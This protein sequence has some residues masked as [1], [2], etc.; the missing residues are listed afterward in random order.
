MASE[1]W[2][3]FKTPAPPPSPC[4]RSRWDSSSTRFSNDARHS[5]HVN[6]R[7]EEE[8]EGMTGGRGAEGRLPEFGGLPPPF[9]AIE[10]RRASLR[11]PPEV[12]RV[13]FREAVRPSL[14]SHWSEIP[15]L[16]C[17]RTPRPAEES[18]EL[19]WNERPG[20][21]V[22]RSICGNPLSLIDAIPIDQ[23]FAPKSEL[24]S[25]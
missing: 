2:G 10:A 3:Q 17:R 16:N 4:W 8:E 11:R 20:R 24:Y 14:D 5:G 7:S 23:R 21:D 9:P 22:L 25:K 1:Q 6:L 19:T 12:W 15:G 13:P 18:A